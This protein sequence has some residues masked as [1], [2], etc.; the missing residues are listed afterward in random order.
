MGLKFWMSMVLKSSC[1]KTCNKKLWRCWNV[2]KLFW[3]LMIQIKFIAMMLDPSFIHLHVWKLC[4]SQ[5]YNPFCNWTWCEGMPLYM[6]Y[7]HW[8]N[9]YCPNEKPMDLANMLIMTL[10]YL[11][12]E[13]LLKSFH[14]QLLELFFC[15]GNCLDFWLHVMIPLL[16]GTSMRRNFQML[17][18]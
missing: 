9:P 11:V 2:F 1:N 17:H 15:L 7:F 3:K 16:S 8:L 18:S 14:V 10:I 12:L 13:H 6:T 5:K 4:G